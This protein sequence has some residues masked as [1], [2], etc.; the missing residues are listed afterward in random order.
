MI[1]MYSPGDASDIIIPATYITHASYSAIRSLIGSSDT[2]IS[3]LPTVSALI[4]PEDIWQWPLLTL[5]ILLLLPSFLA[6][7]TLLF[8]RVRQVRAERRDR[9]PEAVVQSLPCWVWAGAGEMVRPSELDPNDGAAKNGL[10]QRAADTSKQGEV[11]VGERHSST[12]FALNSA[13]RASGA[14][15]P[16]WFLGQTECAICLSSYVNGDLVRV[17]PCNHIFH[18]E[19]IDGWLIQRKKLCPI[20]KAD[21]TVPLPA[22]QSCI[23]SLGPAPS[24][25]PQPCQHYPNDHVRNL[26]PSASPQSPQFPTERTPLITQE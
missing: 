8:H 26:S 1:T 11:G 3:G 20:C 5:S 25:P 16:P 10:D 6:L 7:L 2:T 13:C 19:E 24:H 21:V 15:L 9:A 18:Q 4:G 14:R 17:L 12:S 23:C 22:P